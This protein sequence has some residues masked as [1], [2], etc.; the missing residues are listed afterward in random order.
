M[1]ARAITAA[2]P[3]TVTALAPGLEVDWKPM[4]ANT[5][6]GPTLQ[7]DSTSPQPITKCGTAPLIANDLTTT[8]IAKVVYDGSN[9]QLQNPQAADCTSVTTL[10]A[11]SSASVPLGGK[12]YFGFGTNSSSTNE[13][14]AYLPIATS[15]TVVALHAT[16]SATPAQQITIHARYKG[17]NFTSDL[18]CPLTTSVTSCDVTGGTQSIVESTN[19]S[20]TNWDIEADAANSGSASSRNYAI[21]LKVV[22][23]N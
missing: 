6:A 23:A 21:C 14:G 8:A 10:C 15:G 4:A 17:A 22:G 16:V 2:M 18:T 3:Q 1:T 13:P 7:V 11:G 19:A 9:F 20:P 12:L 5:G